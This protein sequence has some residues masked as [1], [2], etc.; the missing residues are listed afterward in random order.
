[1][2]LTY[3]SS[4]DAYEETCT[5]TGSKTAFCTKEES[6][7]ICVNVFK[8]NTGEKLEMKR[9]ITDRLC[10]CVVGCKELISLREHSM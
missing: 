2:F 8:G 6:A 9:N 7:G 10:G 5:A 1:M 4:E 3:C